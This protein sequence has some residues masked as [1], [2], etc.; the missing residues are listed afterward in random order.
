MDSTFYLKHYDP[1][2]WRIE[3]PNSSSLGKR[4]EA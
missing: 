3:T 1:E 4:P 2:R